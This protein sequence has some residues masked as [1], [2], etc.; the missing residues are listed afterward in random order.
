MFLVFS[1]FF[2]VTAAAQEASGPPVRPPR[3]VPLATLPQTSWAYRGDAA[4]FT[5]SALS[6]LRGHGAPLVQLVPAD[7]ATWCP[8]YAEGDARR[9]RA[10]WVGFLSALARHE[11]THNPQ[12]VGG[13]GRWHGLLQIAPA[14]ARGHG[15]R[16]TSGEALRHGPDNL[17][18]AIRIMARTVPRDGVISAGGR[19]VAADWGPLHSAAKRA[20]MQAWLRGQSYCRPLASVRPRARPDRLARGG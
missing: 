18:C 10:F 20:Q 6:A 9:R 2:S 5:L 13:G 19:G 3:D 1:V 12:A 4:L 14:T 7:I 17:S 16:A 15:C 8:G 11:S